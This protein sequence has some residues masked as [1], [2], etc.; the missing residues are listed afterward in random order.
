MPCSG[1]HDGEHGH[2]GEA[3]HGD[4]FTSTARGSY[5][6]Q[7]AHRGGAGGGGAH[8][9]ARKMALGNLVAAGGCRR[10]WGRTAATGDVEEGGRCSSAS[11]L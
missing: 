5:G 2:G 1:E 3:I 9:A 10:S 7:G 4:G 6:A 11:E 8:R